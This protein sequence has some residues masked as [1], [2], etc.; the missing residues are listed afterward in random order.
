MEY[1]EFEIIVEQPYYKDKWGNKKYDLEGKKN[2]KGIDRINPGGKK[3][4]AICDEKAKI[5]KWHEKG[6]KFLLE[7]NISE[8][9]AINIVEDEKIFK[10]KR[11]NEQQ[12]ID[13]KE[14]VFN[15]KPD[16]GVTDQK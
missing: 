11:L 9:E 15:I 1:I 10:A 3:Y 5:H 8:V 4:P 7:L 12:A 14:E 2:R 13:M 6:E 16:S